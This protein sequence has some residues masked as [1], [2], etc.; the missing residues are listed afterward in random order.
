M[1][2]DVKYLLSPEDPSMENECP[3]NFEIYVPRGVVE[4][5]VAG[6]SRLPYN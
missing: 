4:N 6:P 3:N 5:A 1:Y 2:E